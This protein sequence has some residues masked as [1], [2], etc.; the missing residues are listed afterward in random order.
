VEYLRWCEKEGRLA[1]G[2]EDG[3]NG[4]GNRKMAPLLIVPVGIVY[5]DKS[6]YLSRVSQLV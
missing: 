1:Q 2:Q 4:L 3:D 6:R 5:T